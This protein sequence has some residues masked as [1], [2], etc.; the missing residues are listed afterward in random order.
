[1][2]THPSTDQLL[3]DRLTETIEDNLQNEQFGVPELA[4][5]VELSKSQLNRRLQVITNQSASQFIREY[6]LKK[7]HELLQ[8][9]TATPTEVAYKIGFGSPSYFSTCFK[10]FY[11]YSPGEVN[12]MKPVNQKKKTTIAWKLVLISLIAVL[13]ITVFY[14]SFRT[15]IPKPVTKD[16]QPLILYKSIAVI[17]FWNDS[18]DSSTTY[19]CVGIEDEIRLHLDK[20]TDLK[21]K[22]RQSIEV[23]RGNPGVDIKTIAQDLN[24][25][26][27]VGGSVRMTGNEVRIIV[28]LINANTED[29]IW[30]NAYNGAYSDKILDFQV[31]AAKEIATALN[32][33]ITPSEENRIDKRITSNMDAYDFFIKG[34]YEGLLYYKT[35]NERHL[36]NSHHFLDKALQIDPYFLQACILKASKYMLEAKWDSMLVYTNQAMHID[37]NNPAV[38]TRKA[39]Y[40]QNVG[41]PDSAIQNL[42]IAHNLKSDFM[43]TNL[44]L[45]EM[46]FYYKRDIKKGLPYLLRSIELIDRN[47]PGDNFDIGAIFL[48]FGEYEL[49]KIFLQKSLELGATC[50]AFSSLNFAQYLQGNYVSIPNYKDSICRQLDCQNVC[51][52]W[53]V[54]FSIYQGDFDAAQDYIEKWESNS[55]QINY[56]L[57]GY[58][59]YKTGKIEDADSIFDGVIERIKPQLISVFGGWNLRYELAQI[60]AIRND[61]DSSLRMVH[62]IIKRGYAYHLI[63]MT[64]IDPMFENLWDNPKFKQIL[65][66]LHDYQADFRFQFRALHKSKPN[67]LNDINQT[68]Q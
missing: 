44:Q 62:E 6:R 59:A 41:E 15:I 23:Y 24:V 34:K 26:F 48:Q 19:F 22:P 56:S 7:A 67:L 13:L 55:G 61:I 33:I 37:P 11:G 40:Y 21:I 39:R 64:T 27:I 29:Q 30:S 20:I 2:N 18:P 68:I 10:E 54:R 47:H 16:H 46:Y 50:R 45:C 12:Q 28:Y 17:P 42:L 53:H 25:P 35:L 43:R 63:N 31:N 3:L 51:N 1:M 60:Y 52:G 14:F 49:A 8:S 36:K 32:A 5:A 66:E 38:Y 9:K 58:V 57:I 65:E 4:E